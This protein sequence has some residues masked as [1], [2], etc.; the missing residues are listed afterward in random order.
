GEHYTGVNATAAATY[1]VSAL[2]GGVIDAERRAAEERRD[3]RQL[4]AVKYPTR[5]TIV[6]V[7]AQAGDFVDVVDRQVVRAIKPRLAVV[8]YTRVDERIDVVAVSVHHIHRL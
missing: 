1:Q 6:P 4:P 8:T 5:E 3:A 2:H 7:L